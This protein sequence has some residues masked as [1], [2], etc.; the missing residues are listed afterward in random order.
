MKRIL[1]T[2][3][4]LSIFLLPLNSFSAVWKPLGKMDMGG[5]EVTIYV[6]KF[7]IQADKE[8]NEFKRSWVKFELPRNIK[9][10][11][12]D[13]LYRSREE[14][15]YFHCDQNLY[16]VTHVKLTNSKDEIIYDS[17]EF[18]P[19]TEDFDKAWKLIIPVSGPDLVNTYV[20]KLE[21]YNT[22]DD[23]VPEWM[24][25]KE[26][27]TLEAPSLSKNIMSSKIS[28]KDIRWAM[29][30]DGSERLVFDIYSGE[31][32]ISKPDNYKVIDEAKDKAMDIL[33]TG[34]E[35]VE[36]TLPDLGQSKIIEKISISNDEENQGVNIKII[37][38]ISPEYKVFEVENPGRLVVD[39]V[40]ID[41][42]S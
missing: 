4:L 25:K 34:Y 17:G 20:C 30:D 39:F 7:S 36:T 32:K 41:E 15:Y 27:E 9:S 23:N 21:H 2:A 11:Y 40:L 33:F 1:L 13:E 16:T 8:N 38:K 18:N 26:A 6:D 12:N 22:R 29:R 37:F 19:F 42:T 10:D 35:S 24:K 14:L 31:E 5:M 28:L 3:I